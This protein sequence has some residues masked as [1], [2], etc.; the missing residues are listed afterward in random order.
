LGAITRLPAFAALIPLWEKINFFHNY[1]ASDFA[2][3]S[4]SGG[5]CSVPAFKT[6]SHCYRPLTK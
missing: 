5:L 3:L 6:K 2:F 4:A 1:L